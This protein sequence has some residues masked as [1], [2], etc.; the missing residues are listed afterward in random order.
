[1]SQKY[2]KK[3]QSVLIPKYGPHDS[4]IL[5]PSSLQWLCK[6][7][8]SVLSTHAAQIDAIQL[9]YS[10]GH[11]FAYDAWQGVLIKTDLN[12]VLETMA[13]IMI[14][15]VGPAID[16]CFGME[17]E[18]WKELDLFPACRMITG[19]VVMGFQ[20]GDSAEGR[21]LCGFTLCNG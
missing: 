20:V 16:N 12:A 1:M 19:K 8:D 21:K 9:D 4:V 10:L 15:Q 2:S 3:G 13:S 5:P 7:P 14:E 11:K 6:Q 17:T 18:E